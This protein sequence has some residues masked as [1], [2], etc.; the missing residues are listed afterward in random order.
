MF[1]SSLCCRSA[2]QR[3]A[4]LQVCLPT[5]IITRTKMTI[6]LTANLSLFSPPSYDGWPAWVNHNLLSAVVP[7]PKKSWNFK[8]AYC[9]YLP[10]K[11]SKICHRL[12]QAICVQYTVFKEI[13]TFILCCVIF[14]T[15]AVPLSFRTDLCRKQWDKSQEDM[16]LTLLYVVVCLI[17]SGSFHHQWG[18]SRIG[19]FQ[20]PLISTILYYLGDFFFFFWSVKKR[21]LTLWMLRL[22]T[23]S[24]KSY[25]QLV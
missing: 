22:R 24:M 1:T 4:S 9:M 8:T 17:W 21:Y 15:F 5:T 23:H 20:Q 12:R 13:D 3:L 11:I 10:G 19:T 25:N 14:P 16:T 18:T 7:V 2:I 6:R